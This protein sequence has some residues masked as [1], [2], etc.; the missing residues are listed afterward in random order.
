ML[1]LTQKSQI[2]IILSLRL[3]HFSIFFLWN[4]KT[5][6]CSLYNDDHK[7]QRFTKTVTSR[8]YVTVV[9]FLS[10][11]VLISRLNS[12]LG[13]GRTFRGMGWRTKIRLES[14]QSGLAPAVGSWTKPAL[15][16][17]PYVKKKRYYGN[18]TSKMPTRIITTRSLFSRG[19]CT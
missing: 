2:F 18:P 4:F 16:R 14:K 19:C 11:A 15:L 10:S 3:F 7:K 1:S 5:I 17:K 9:V 13:I 6:T 12:M 8:N